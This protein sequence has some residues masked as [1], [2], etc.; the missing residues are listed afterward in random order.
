L[1]P[2]ELS[3]LLTSSPAL[4]NLTLCEAS[5]EVVIRFDPFGGEPRNCDLLVR[6]VCGIGNV[7]ISVEAK[8][9]ETFNETVGKSYDAAM[10]RPGSNAPERMRR[11][12]QAVLGANVEAVRDLRYQLLYGT[13]AALSAAKQHGAATAVFV[14]HEFITERTD[15]IKH[16]KNSTDLNDF[17]RTLT[18]DQSAR[19]DPGQLVGPFR[20]PG[21]D[22]IPKEVVLFIG[23]A[24]RNTRL[25]RRRTRILGNKAL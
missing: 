4:A 19:L 2:H 22:D 18:G 15:D 20:V 3:S 8:A 9:D 23:K 12:A 16:Q 5:P 21:N 17:L 10:V 14:V 25:A 1:I 13:A 24:V 11:L 6:G 7:I